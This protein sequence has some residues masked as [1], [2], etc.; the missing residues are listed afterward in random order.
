MDKGEYAHA[1]LTKVKKFNGGLFR[2]L[3]SSP[4]STTYNSTC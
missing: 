1:L 3:F 4:R 2:D